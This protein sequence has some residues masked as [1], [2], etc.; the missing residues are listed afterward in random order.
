MYERGIKQYA[1]EAVYD[2]CVILWIK[3]KFTQLNAVLIFLLGGMYLVENR[4]STDTKYVAHQLNKVICYHG[5]DLSGSSLYL[6]GAGFL[7]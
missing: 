6:D 3:I 7:H 1:Y 5:P 4:H 2:N